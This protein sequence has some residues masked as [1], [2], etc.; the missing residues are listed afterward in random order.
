MF[1]PFINFMAITERAVLNQRLTPFRFE[2]RPT[3]LLSQLSSTLLCLLECVVQSER[4][5]ESSIK[6]I[7]L[8]ATV[9]ILEMA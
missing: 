6:R 2:N 3:T 1:K 8:L 7:P 4:P 5:L 9:S